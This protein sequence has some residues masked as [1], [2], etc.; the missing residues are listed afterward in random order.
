MHKRSDRQLTTELAAI[1]RLKMMYP[2]FHSDPIHFKL[3]GNENMPNILISCH[4]ESQNDHRLIKLGKMM[5]LS[6]FSDIVYDPLQVKGTC[7]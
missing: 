6:F 1:E 2:R 3:A 7:I 5:Y 4:W